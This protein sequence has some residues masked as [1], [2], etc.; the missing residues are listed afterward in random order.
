MP[1]QSRDYSKGK[2]YTIRS[3]SNPRLIYV[4]STTTELSKRWYSHKSGF[5]A[6]K[7][8]SEQSYCGS[9]EII[10]LGDAYWELH[11]NYPCKYLAELEKREGEVMRQFSEDEKYDCM[12]IIAP[13]MCYDEYKDLDMPN[14][15]TRGEYMHKRWE[16]WRFAQE[17]ADA[18][19]WDGKC[20]AMRKDVS[21][22]SDEKLV[23]AWHRE[24]KRREKVSEDRYD[25]RKEKCYCGA[26]MRVWEGEYIIG[27]DGLF[28]KTWSKV[29]QLKHTPQG[30]EQHDRFVREKLAGR[31][32]CECGAMVKDL[33][34]HS[35]RS[36]F[37][38]DYMAVW[39]FIYS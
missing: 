19:K 25:F 31:S 8:D 14:K 13:S 12:N 2:I 35:K 7:K 33:K 1:R 27:D 20:G 6:W 28:T 34:T 10:K 4:G 21:K 30:R 9:Y 17:L 15:K 38:I 37:H 29:P 3:K 18:K 24:E 39:N 5:N 23:E 26:L 36:K 11:E 32:V 16:A 22:L